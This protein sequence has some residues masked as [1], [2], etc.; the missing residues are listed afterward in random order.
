MEFRLKSRSADS[1]SSVHQFA[2]DELVDSEMYER[3]MTDGYMSTLSFIKGAA[4]SIGLDIDTET[5]ERWKR[6]CNAAYL[7]D[8]F[9]D[10]APDIETACTQYEAG[11]EQAF[12]VSGEALLDEEPPTPDADERLPSAILLLKNSVSTLP[13]NQL[14][15]LKE[16]ATA[17]GDITRRKT[18]CDNTADYT[19]L[20][21]RE[22]FHTSVL[23]AAS[24]SQT[25]Q[26]Q[27]QFPDFVQWCQ[28]AMELGT[29]GDCAID[30]KQDNEQQI[31]AVKPSV[32]NI[33]K[34]ALQAYKPGRAMIHTVTQR[35]A[36]IGSLVERSKFRRS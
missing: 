20:L 35:R 9:L 32:K 11:M 13:D 5:M 8:D 12:Q 21:K 36:T 10:T 17:I 19:Y 30:L 3:C 2:G 14:T 4:E 16:A 23:I 29:L 1:L 33:A 18:T 28:H 7:I 26:Q 27:A 22:A 6:V 34:I 31:T 24:T 15:S 25:V